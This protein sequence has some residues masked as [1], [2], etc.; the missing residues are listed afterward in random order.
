MNVTAFT[1]VVV[2]GMSGCAGRS[3][4][5]IP[6]EPT[7]ISVREAM[8]R[9]QDGRGQ[10]ATVVGI[11]AG[12]SSSQRFMLEDD[13]AAT[14]RLTVD[15]SD[16]ETQKIETGGRWVRV[17][18]LLQRKSGQMILMA[19]AVEMGE[20]APQKEPERNHRSPMPPSGGGHHH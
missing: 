20:L 12:L 10:L 17:Y 11:A 2:A 8:T 1:W 13:L 18:G 15:N 4:I 14:Q 7:A 9:V 3:W 6:A 16:P 5:K 19:Q